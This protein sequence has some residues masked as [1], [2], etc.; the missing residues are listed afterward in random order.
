MAV[1]R[2]NTKLSTALPI[3]GSVIL[4]KSS[5]SQIY[6][7]NKI[8]PMTAD[9]ALKSTC[10]IASCLLIACPP[11]EPRT[12]VNVVPMLA[13]ITIAIDS[14]NPIIP[15]LI[16]ARVKTHVAVLDCKTTVAT[17]PTIKNAGNQISVYAAKS[18]VA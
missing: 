9:I 8:T 5:T 12:A 13:H 14:G 4:S 15:A 6:G 10:H 17:I 3:I 11:S 2:L 16:A 7:R 18:N 1:L